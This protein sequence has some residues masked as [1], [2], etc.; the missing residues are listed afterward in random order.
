MK[1]I[2]KIPMR[3]QDVRQ[4]KRWLAALQSHANKHHRFREGDF[5]DY[6]PSLNCFPTNAAAIRRYFVWCQSHKLNPTQSRSMCLYWGICEGSENMPPIFRDY[7]VA[8]IENLVGPTTQWLTQDD[9]DRCYHDAW[10]IVIECFT[11]DAEYCEKNH[12]CDETYDSWGEVVARSPGRFFKKQVIIRLETS[13]MFAFSA[14]ER[15]SV[16]SRT[17]FEVD[18]ASRYNIRAA[19][20]ISPRHNAD[21]RDVID[22]IMRVSGV[23]VPHK[24]QARLQR[25]AYRTSKAIERERDRAW[26]RRESRR[27]RLARRALERSM[28]ELDGDA[29]KG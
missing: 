13:Q 11:D 9:D 23:E 10:K 2:Q 18:S 4:V 7:S 26:K 19:T 15:V 28:I 22:A 17:R 21:L 5:E 29:E 16:F 20:Q 25:Y 3:R 12:L 8:M 27:K 14:D 24:W 1:L 6:I